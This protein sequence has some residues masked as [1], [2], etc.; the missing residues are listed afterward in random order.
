M[1][2]ADNQFTW[3][4][5]LS[6]IKTTLRRRVTGSLV[7]GAEAIPGLGS[8]WTYQY[9]INEFHFMGK[10]VRGE[11]LYALQEDACSESRG[12][13]EVVGKRKWGDG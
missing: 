3:R 10:I 13:T 12:Y 5:R 9:S 8:R 1:G 2:V 7:A 11:F 4:I 6:E